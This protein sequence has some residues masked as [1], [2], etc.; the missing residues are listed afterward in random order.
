MAV[1]G[2]VRKISWRTPPST[3]LRTLSHSFKRHNAP[4]MVIIRTTDETVAFLVPSHAIHAASMTMQ[5]VLASQRSCMR[6]REVLLP[7]NHLYTEQ[8]ASAYV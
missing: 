5:H 4:Y 1:C 7:H 8:F 3:R 6:L 2:T